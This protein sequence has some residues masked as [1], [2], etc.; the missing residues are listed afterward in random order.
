DACAPGAP[1]AGRAGRDG[2]RERE[3]PVEADDDLVELRHHDAQAAAGV[4]L[5][6]EIGEARAGVAA[7]PERDRADAHEEE[8]ERPGARLD[9]GGR[10][11]PPPERPPPAR[12]PA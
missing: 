9:V 11:R 5:P 3:G 10:P 1:G 8:L 7:V 2:P 12:A 4:V 6:V